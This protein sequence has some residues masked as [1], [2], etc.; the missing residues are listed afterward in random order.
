MDFHTPEDTQEIIN[1]LK[2]FVEKV[3]IPLEEKTEI[4]FTTNV[5]TT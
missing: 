4:Y 1:A 5:I 2:Q 3:V